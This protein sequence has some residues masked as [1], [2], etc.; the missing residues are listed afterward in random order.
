MANWFED[1][2][3]KSVISYTLLIAGATWA[4]STFVLQDNRLNLARSELESQKTSTEQY[5]S[6]VELLQRDIELLRSENA[7]YRNW[8]GQTKDAIPVIVPRIAD[9]K[10][11]VTKLETELSH[12][13][14]AS[15]AS[16]NLAQDHTVQIG[17]AFVDETTGL[18]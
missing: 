4:I 8:L 3:G 6:K 13:R 7:E 15:P 5:K 9:L 2:P 11:K 14:D 18:I 10:E 16:P 1:N 17:S 12:A